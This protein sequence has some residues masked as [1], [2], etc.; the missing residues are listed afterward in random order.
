MDIKSFFFATLPKI[1]SIQQLS[2]QKFLFPIQCIKMKNTATNSNVMVRNNLVKNKKE[3]QT[4][5]HN[6]VV[7][8]FSYNCTQKHMQCCRNTASS[9]SANWIKA[10]IWAS[11]KRKKENNTC[12]NTLWEQW[13]HHVQTN[14]SGF[15]TWVKCVWII[16]CLKN[17][18]ELQLN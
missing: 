6:P 13:R 16:S 10:Q 4:D 2:V 11:I 18:G 9:S 1:Q 15:Y 3:S 8:C 7:I 5:N 14:S 17:T 12:L